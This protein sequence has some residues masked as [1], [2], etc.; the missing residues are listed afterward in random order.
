MT[1]RPVTKS[2]RDVWLQMRAALWPD[3]TE[4]ELGIEVDQFL[5]GSKS[6]LLTTVFVSADVDGLLTGFIELFVRNVAEGCNGTTP[7]VEGW[8]VSPDWRNQGVGRALMDAAETWS[9]S[10]GF[11]EL[12]SDT[13]ADNELSQ[14][15]HQR[16]GFE[17]AERSV[18]FR[19][20][21]EPSS[22][23]PALNVQV[24]AKSE[25]DRLTESFFALFSNRDGAPEL[26]RIFEL[27]VPNGIIAKCTSV[28]PEL[29]TLREFI[30]PRQ[31][32]LTSGTLTEFSESE[33]SERTQI[34]GNIAQR[35]STYQKSGCL[36]GVPFSTR[37]VKTFQFVRT[38]IG[39]RILSVTWDDER[40]GL[41]IEEL[42]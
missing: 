13:T 30:A 40:E 36:D 42:S 31:V 11:N 27:F 41:A 3:Q 35:I 7:H 28:D 2:D 37:G 34:F 18:H 10:R 5:L 19:K 8:Y 14:A 20:T 22:G 12:A 16:L 33:T 38:R 26:G 32:L 6:S 25:L 17:I 24:G 21:L 4:A 9:R 39:W 1:I 23:V 15:A 29:T